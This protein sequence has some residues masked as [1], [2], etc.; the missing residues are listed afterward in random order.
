M[1]WSLN[2]TAIDIVLEF[3]FISLNSFHIYPGVS[4]LIL[5]E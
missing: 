2:S 3:L 1:Y 4:I 5:N